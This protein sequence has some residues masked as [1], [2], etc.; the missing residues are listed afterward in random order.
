MIMI[1]LTID[2]ATGMTVKKASH[3]NEMLLPEVIDL[4]KRLNI[5]PKVFT[6]VLQARGQGSVSLDSLGQYC[7]SYDEIALQDNPLIAPIDNKLRMSKT[8]LHEIIHWTG[9]SSR[10][11]RIKIVKSE[12]YGPNGVMLP[13][14]CGEMA[15]EECIA[16]LGAYRL[17]ARLGLDTRALAPVI[18]S[19]LR[20]FG[21]G[22]LMS[23]VCK[24]A[25]YAIDYVIQLAYQN[26]AA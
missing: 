16:E 15:F 5:V 4:C 26:K 6:E 12:S 13:F 1:T 17:A 10:L 25:N 3:A 14:E 23:E 21:A 8:M 2:L 19:Y 7:G 18:D 20:V 11:A 22:I 9:H 24:E